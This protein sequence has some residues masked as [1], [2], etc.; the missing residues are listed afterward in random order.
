MSI[1]DTSYGDLRAQKIFQIFHSEKI[2]LYHKP[3]RKVTYFPQDKLFF[4]VTTDAALPQYCQILCVG[5]CQGVSSGKSV[6]TEGFFFLSLY[7]RLP[8]KEIRK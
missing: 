5:R 7:F 2:L 3:Y 6:I 1:Q 8:W 4:P